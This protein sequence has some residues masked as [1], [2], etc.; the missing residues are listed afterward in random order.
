MSEVQ[1]PTFN[2]E[3]SELVS[4]LYD[5]FRAGLEVSVQMQERAHNMGVD[6]ARI[7]N[8]VALEFGYADSD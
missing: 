5:R 4:E 3:R 7:E 2:L 6:V 1:D 8:C